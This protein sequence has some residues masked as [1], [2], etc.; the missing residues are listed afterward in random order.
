MDNATVGQIITFLTVIAGFI[1]QA[2][3]EQR[4]RRWD[5]EDRLQ[6]AM[7]SHQQHE[8]AT[9]ARQDIKAAMVE[10]TELTRAAI[11]S[12]D[13]AYHEANTVNVKIQ[14]LAESA[15]AA[16]Q[17][18]QR[19][20]RRSTDAVRADLKVGQALGLT[21]LGHPPDVSEGSR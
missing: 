20:E 11:T 3:R 13:N 6:V 14:Q 10:N 15:N 9:T 21:G 1:Y 18:E 16:I 8:A 12:A 5:V 4:Q 2:Y 17:A 19:G 7:L